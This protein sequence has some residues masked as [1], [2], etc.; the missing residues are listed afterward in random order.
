MYKKY[1]GDVNITHYY[2]MGLKKFILRGGILD[3]V[4]LRILYQLNY[5]VNCSYKVINI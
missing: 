2:Q 4:T 5:S 3:Y 1:R